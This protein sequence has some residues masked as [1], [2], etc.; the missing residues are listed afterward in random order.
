MNR[1]LIC[2]SLGAGLLLSALAQ[3]YPNER[4]SRDREQNYQE[5]S[6]LIPA[7]TRIPVRTDQAI[8]ARDRSDGRIFTGTVAEDVRGQDGRI[9]IP[10]SARAELIVQNVAANDLTVDL[11]S[12]T[13]DGRRYMVNAQAYDNARHT[14][15]GE[16]KRTG[17]YVGGGAILGAIVG[18]IAGGGKGA[19]IGAVAGGAAGAGAQ[20]LTRGPQIRI[21]AETILTFRLNQPLEVGRGPY[22]RDN[23][24][25]SD[26]NHYHNDYYHREPR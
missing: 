23:G 7:D 19:A 1:T 9:L 14:R 21:P 10:R 16:N 20:V 2:M 8:D 24:Y 3:Q 25:D 6:D 22:S 13:V 26:G 4:N 17:Q 11:D 5:R 18:A 12:I 15:L